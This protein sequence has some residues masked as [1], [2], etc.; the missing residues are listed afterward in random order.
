MFR[1]ALMWNLWKNKF[2]LLVQL[3]SQVK[4]LLIR[5]WIQ[6]LSLN[7]NKAI[8]KEK[9]NKLPRKTQKWW[10]SSDQRNRPS[11]LLFQSQK[12]V[13]L[14]KRNL[15]YLRS[16]LIKINRLTIKTSSL[17]KIAKRLHWVLSKRRMKI[18][19]FLMKLSILLKKRILELS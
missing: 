8:L 6:E 5:K 9:L 7:K 12:K 11:L 19:S 10:M 2:F 15:S 18:K 14:R 16:T 3:L 13:L 17:K 4:K 1:R